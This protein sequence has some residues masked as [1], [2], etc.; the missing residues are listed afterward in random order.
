MKP[1]QRRYTLTVTE[2]QAHALQDACEVAARIGMYQVHDICRF[3]PQASDVEK[4]A[5]D[6][7][8]EQLWDMYL[9][10][11]QQA[12]SDSQKPPETVTLW[13]LYQVIRYR[14]SWDAHPEGNNMSVMFD[15]PLRMGK[16]ELAK[17][18]ED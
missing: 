17:I 1:T 11:T 4:E 6:E 14:L 10:Y 9:K 12:F 3:L 16:C 5:A 18:E 15:K 13:D 7:I 2:E 8:Y